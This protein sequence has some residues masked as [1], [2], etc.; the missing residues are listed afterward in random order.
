M[1]NLLPFKIQLLA[2]IYLARWR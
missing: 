2:H 1:D